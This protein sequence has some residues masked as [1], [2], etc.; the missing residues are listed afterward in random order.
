MARRP[1]LDSE[2]S[3][4]HIGNRGI[5]RRPVFETRDDIRF[6][7][8]HVA[9]AVRRAEFEVHAYC[10][11]TTHY[12]LL[13][14]CGEGGLGQ[15]MWEIQTSYSRR[16][17]RSRRRDGPLVRGRFWSRLVTGLTYRR[18]LVR[19]IDRNPLLAGVG[20]P[21]CYPHCSARHYARSS[22]PPWLERSWIEGEV[23]G[24]QQD[25]AYEPSKY[26][27]VFGTGS[28]D[29]A[30][31]VDARI[32]ST[33]SVDDFEDLVRASPAAVQR[34]FRKKAL[35]ADGTR[36]GMPV[37]TIARV[38]QV[39]RAHDTESWLVRTARKEWNAW[40]VLRVGLERDL[41]AATFEIMAN[42]AG[43]NPRRARR[44]YHTH[45]RLT[46]DD[47]NYARVCAEL[48]VRCLAPY[49]R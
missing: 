41:A 25:R 43:T 31:L 12:H 39:C 27:A 24:G 35:L 1:R 22:G 15:S 26:A 3:W 40:T 11:L 14:R 19:Y 4:H 9:R 16:F 20:K 32:R 8:S 42:H 13:V 30:R 33:A 23:S 48:S 38:A 21:R 17:N 46:L 2:G 29:E 6:F 7:L 5:A 44:L 49:R 28:S 45:R 10:I 47:A 34:W 37:A 36:P 18:T